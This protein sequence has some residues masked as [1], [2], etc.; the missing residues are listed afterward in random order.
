M[1]NK[2]SHKKKKISVE[3]AK[4]LVSNLTDAEKDQI[5]NL[6]L[7][8]MLHNLASQIV[9]LQDTLGMKLSFKLAYPISSEDTRTMFI[10]LSPHENT[11]KSMT[12]QSSEE[13]EQLE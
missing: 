5:I 6:K 11:L 10:E 12:E 2:H 7:R 9:H 8:Q 4:L 13:S 3:Q 1:S